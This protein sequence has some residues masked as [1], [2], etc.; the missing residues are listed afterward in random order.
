MYK[1]VFIDIDGTLKDS[2]GNINQ[3]TIN[4][5]KKFLV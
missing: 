4:A 1:A 2:K 5:I 3:R